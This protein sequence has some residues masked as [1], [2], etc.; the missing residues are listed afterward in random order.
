M[1][2]MI[3]LPPLV[4]EA[5]S[6]GVGAA[7]LWL[8][9]FVTEQIRARKHEKQSGAIFEAVESGVKILGWLNSVMVDLQASRVL[10]IC[11]KNGGDVPKPGS[12]LSATMIYEVFQGEGSA[13]LRGDF[14]SV[15][16]DWHYLSMLQD[17]RHK[18]HIV[19]VRK[20][21]PEGSILRNTYEQ[22]AADWAI[23]YEIMAAPGKYF[24]LVLP[25]GPGV[26]VE[27]STSHHFEYQV[28]VLANKIKVELEEHYDQP[29]SQ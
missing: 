10:V 4:S 17:L 5:I 15:S 22:T 12:S 11:A 27:M 23:V 8:V 13:S 6:I 19:L 24:Y 7:C 29:E 2:T 26:P 9:K 21:M 25:F 16:L 28:R 1:E 20:D 14:V 3:E 18:G